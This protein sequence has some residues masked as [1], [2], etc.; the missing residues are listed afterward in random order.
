MLFETGTDLLS[1]PESFQQLDE[2]RRA[3]KKAMLQGIADKRVIEIAGHTD[4]VGSPELN[5][6]LS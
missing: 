2:A 5:M 4:N 6:K 3:F 1:S